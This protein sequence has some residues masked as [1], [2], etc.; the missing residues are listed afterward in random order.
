MTTIEEIRK[1]KE[2]AEARLDEAGAELKKFKEGEDGGMWLEDLRGKVRR[3]EQL[4]KDDKRQLERLEKEEERLK[5]NVDDRLK[6]VE[7]L[8]NKLAEFGKEEGNEQIV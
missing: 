2:K 4:D 7:Y 6:Q 3:K 5:K 8:Q 1:V